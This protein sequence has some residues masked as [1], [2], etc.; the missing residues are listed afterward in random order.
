MREMEKAIL[1]C[2]MGDEDGKMKDKTRVSRK[3]G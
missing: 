3:V 1:R 2:S